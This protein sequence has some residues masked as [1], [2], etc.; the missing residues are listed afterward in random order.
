MGPK[1]T[2]SEREQARKG[3]GSAKYPSSSSGA[4]SS[5]PSNSQ[6]LYGTSSSYR[7]TSQNLH[8]YPSSYTST[9][10]HQYGTSSSSRRTSQT[11]YGTSAGSPPTSQ[12]SYDTSPSYVPASRSQYDYSSSY[13]SSSQ[14]PYGTTSNYSPTFQSSYRAPTASTR[15]NFLPRPPTKDDPNLEQSSDLGE[16]SVPLGEY[17]EYL[18]NNY[19][20]FPAPVLSATASDP[21]AHNPATSSQAAPASFTSTRTSAGS[22]CASAG[23]HGP[24]PYSSSNL[25]DLSQ[26]QREYFE[27]ALGSVHSA[28]THTPSY[29]STSQNPYLTSS[30]SAYTGHSIRPSI[31]AD[32]NTGQVLN[33]GRPPTD[34]NPQPQGRSGRRSDPASP[35]TASHPHTAPASTRPPTGYSANWTSAELRN[36]ITCVQRS[37]ARGRK[38]INWLWV[39]SEMKSERT[40]G[41][42]E[43]QYSQLRKTRW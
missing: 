3:S 41:E 38:R 20:L 25:L 28:T 34:Q 39:K 22:A 27:G 14:T 5:R 10:Q 32:H 18:S 24:N 33:L 8:N 2:T 40:P 36:L 17:A 29:S 30:A 4:S 6:S 21:S 35:G 13:I 9:S 23:D 37:M 11:P 42:L 16:S 26:E 1:K 19:G 43:S 7:P 31:R 12:S 15:S